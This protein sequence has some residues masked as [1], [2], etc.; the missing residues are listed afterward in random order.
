MTF[1]PSTSS[2]HRLKDLGKLGEDRAIIFL[3]SNGFS[4]IYRNFRAY[5]AEIDVIAE[6]DKTIYFIE[7]KTRSNLSKGQPHEAVNS[8]K[9]FRLRKAAQF[10]LLQNPKKNY[11]LKL[12]V[13]SILFD[14]ANYCINF[15]EDIES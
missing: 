6:K 5:G 7:V 11:K 2:G 12:S 13:I 10:F 3:K 1:Y 15:F 8:S 14:G 4:I 9:L